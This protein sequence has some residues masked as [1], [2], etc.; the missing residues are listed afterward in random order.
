MSAALSGYAAHATMVDVA[1]GNLANL[2]TTGY[3]NNRVHLASLGGG[4]SAPGETG[5]GV[6]VEAIERNSRPGPLVSTGVPTDLAIPGAGF[7]RVRQNKGVVYTRDGAFHLDQDRY[8][9]DAAGNRLEP[10]IQLPPEASSFQVAPSG[11]VTAWDD[12][13]REVFSA[14]L[15]L[16]TF[17]NPAGL[18]GLGFNDYGP[19]TASGPGS[20]VAPGTAGAGTILQGVLEGPDVDPVREMISLMVGQRGFEANLKT[21]QTA[22]TMLG[23]I[24]NLRA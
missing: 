8:V 12:V 11:Q 20:T 15:T 3:K 6:Q 24:I 9:V 2:N 10:E 18:A 14:P 7:F 21:I 19:T 5:R 13:G 1:A 22:D 17:P 16:E 4:A 23:E